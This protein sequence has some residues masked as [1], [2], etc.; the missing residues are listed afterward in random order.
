MRHISKV[1][2]CGGIVRPDDVVSKLV[3][4]HLFWSCFDGF[5]Q[6]RTSYSSEW[7]RGSFGDWP[8][9]EPTGFSCAAFSFAV[10]H[11]DLSYQEMNCACTVCNVIS[12]L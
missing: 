5:C 8:S 11:V 6:R 10:V 9:G 12:L 1:T 4:V 3:M 2:S 7:G